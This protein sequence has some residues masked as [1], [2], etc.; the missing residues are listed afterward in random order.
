MRRFTAL[1][2]GALL[3]GACAS[4]SSEPFAVT[5]P[6]PQSSLATPASSPEPELTPAASPVLDAVAQTRAEGS[7]AVGVQSTAAL[8]S[9]TPWLNIGTGS[10][11]VAKGLGRIAF[12]SSNGGTSEI[13]VNRD[14]NFVSPD[15]GKQ[16]FLLD[17]QQM[18]PLLG[19]VN[20]FRLLAEVPWSEGES[21]TVDGEV[22]TRYDGSV[23]APTI[24]EALDG[25]GVPTEDPLALSQ[26]TNLT[27]DISVW[28]D[29]AGRIVR[30]LRVVDAQTPQ[31]ELQ[32]TE[33]T[34]L[35]DFGKQI[36]L[37]SPDPAKVQPAP[38]N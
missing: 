11:D 27:I 6:A 13:L 26:A 21:E 9:A 16:W 15:G 37:R 32:A 1:L 4:G 17:F 29:G 34:T 38:E 19:S 22:L 5:S 31:G 33:L 30:V 20:V 18:T 14:G 36:D 7:A 8:G 10:L 25:M 3:L 35:T 12:E 23:M 2:G 28:V 24:A